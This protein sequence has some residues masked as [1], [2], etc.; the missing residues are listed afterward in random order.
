MKLAAIFKNGMVLQRN[1]EIHIFGECET[2]E[3]N[4]EVTLGK[5]KSTA[6]IENDKWYCFLPAMEACKGLSL[7]VTSDEETV[8][9]NDIAI[10]EVW[11]AGGQSNMEFELFKSTDG[12]KYIEEAKKYDIR[13]YNV[14]RSSMF[15]DEFY[16]AEKNTYWSKSYDEDVKLW[17][18]V[19]YHFAKNINKELNV[20][21]GIINCNLG[22]TSASV[23]SN[24]DALA[25]DKE[26]KVYIDDYNKIVGDKTID[27]QIKEYDDYLTYADEWN[28]KLEKIQKER[29]ELSWDEMLK[30]VGE[31]KWPGPMGAKNPYRPCGLYE[32]MLKRIAPY[33]IK[34]FIYYQGEEDERRP[35]LYHHLFTTLIKTWRKDF[36]DDNLPFLCVALPMFAYEDAEDN[37]SWPQIRDAQIRASHSLKNVY[38]AIVLDCGELNN[39]HPTEKSPVGKRLSLIALN[40][41]YG[42][43]E[44]DAFGPYFKYANISN[45]I[46]KISFENASNGFDIR[47]ELTGFELSEDGENFFEAKAVL[48]GDNIDVYADEV[49]RPSYIRY[50]WYNYHEVNIFGK[51]G[52]PLAPFFKMI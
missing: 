51:N 34:G 44:V 15:N 43:S 11:L 7:T 30:I 2:N 50:Q 14:P 25:S 4:I 1:K 17:S 32:T 18:A 21:I 48:N 23:W 49:N 36:F 13:Y 46:V 19:A 5:N 35:E 37:K 24:K 10:G 33:T 52:I 12:E 31:C 16:K 41:V 42:K 47:G 27:E 3:K 38:T 45:K 6:K 29:P 40:K 28:K 26:L 9:R 8:I 20:T 22:G 39:I